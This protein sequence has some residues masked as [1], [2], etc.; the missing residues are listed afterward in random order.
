MNI[1]GN[2]PDGLEHA[3][4][5][6]DKEDLLLE[7]LT[8]LLLSSGLCLL[9]LLLLL[10]LEDG[11]DFFTVERLTLGDLVGTTLAHEMLHHV[12]DLLHE[13][14]NG[15]F[16]E[17]HALRQVEWV[18]HILVLLDV[19]LV[20]L[21]QDNGALVVVLAAVVRRAE[22]CDHR[23]ESLMTT[24][25][26][27]LVAVHLDLMSADHRDKVVCAEDFLHRLKTELD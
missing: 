19:H 11:S 13:E 12:S 4:H 6:A 5:S 23:W 3:A 16:E 7:D 8:A 15:P 17:V 27:H 21:D 18:L 25:S 1:R 22:N 20:V 9:V 26:V 24:P 10:L 14:G 2:L